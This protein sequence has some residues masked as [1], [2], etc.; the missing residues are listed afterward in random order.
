VETDGR[1]VDEERGLE[2]C[3]FR[4]RPL[5]R[6]GLAGV[7]RDVN[8]LQRIRAV[9]IEVRE[10]LLDRSVD[11][12]RKLIVS[13]RRGRFGGIARRSLMSWLMTALVGIF[14]V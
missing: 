9:V 4:T 1:V 7:G 5:D 8:R 10:R 11:R 2:T 6:H 13:R 12:D 14:M 3:I